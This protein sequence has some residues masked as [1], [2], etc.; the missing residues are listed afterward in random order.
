MEP[1][2]KIESVFK[3][4]P[5]THKLLEGQWKEPIFEYLKA[6]PWQVTEKVDGTNVRI[7]WD[8]EAIT[9]GGRTDNAQMPTPLVNKLHEL[10]PPG[11]MNSFSPSTALYGEGFG[12]GIQ[13]G[14]DYG[15]VDFILFD[16]KVG[17]WWLEVN[18]VL[19]I[20][21]TLRIRHVPVLDSM[22]LLVAVDLV[23]G[24]LPSVLKDGTAEGVVVR[25][26]VELRTRWGNRL[27]AK[28]KEAD[29][30]D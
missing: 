9:F 12:A 24:T 27:I 29:F 22:P 4:H 21:R 13:K 15:E 30:G 2:H 11:S 5:D 3:R 18:D 14:G 25:P 1:Y 19:E 16:V 8:G 23:K 6:N 10:F 26:A 28:I 20:S 17:E 7:M